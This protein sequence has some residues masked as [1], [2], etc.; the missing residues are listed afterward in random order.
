MTTRARAVSAASAEGGYRW[1]VLALLALAYAC[2]SI[3]R[4]IIAV[5]IEP[6]KAEFHATDRAM[7]LLGGLGYAIAFSIACLPIGWL[8][9]RV[10]RK[11]LFVGLLSLW[12]GLTVLCSFAGSFGALLLCRMGVGAAE[13]GAQPICLSLISDL[14]RPR[15][16]ST[17][18]G[19]FYLSAAVGIAASFLIGGLVAAHFGWRWAFLVAG[20]PGLLLAVLI[21]T[22]LREPQRGRLDGD[23][24]VQPM[25]L[26]QVATQV[27]ATPGLA[28]IAIGA[29]LTSL[30]V[31]AFWVWS[32]SLMIRVHAVPLGYAGPIIA[33]G[34]AA[35]A[36]GSILGGRMADRL[37]E[38]SLA[39]LLVVPITT[40]LLCVPIGIGFAYAP[41]L[42]I[43]LGF[44]FATGFVLGGYLGPC[45]SIVMALVP[46][47]MRGMT[48]AGLQLAINLFGSGVGPLLTGSLSD[49]FGG[50]ESL[51]P[52]LALTMTVN[53]AAAFFL[54]RGRRQVRSS[55]AIM[56]ASASALD[57]P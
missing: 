32:T 34:A 38:K 19:I 36:A 53:I 35:S 1:Y 10:N 22:T 30:T 39:D 42:P 3:D 52:A 28:S 12:S 45:Y 37:A 56:P 11:A 26:R 33:I 6:I 16:R 15:E 47:G 29:T 14:F 40:T 50:P 48:G 57:R 18:I 55:A 43:A 44:L 13:A 31:A 25:P 8:I 27:R 41:T 20:A 49:A 21:V 4:Q 7:G 46:A 5:V 54:I 51:R 23:E 9:D 2:H 24:A 17:A